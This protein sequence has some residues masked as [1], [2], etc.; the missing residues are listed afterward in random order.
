MTDYGRFMILLDNM[1]IKYRTKEFEKHYYID[2]DY[3][4][5]RQTY[6][7]AITIEFDSDGN[8]ITFEAWGE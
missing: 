8:F 7:N 5:I 6:G 4:Y 3:K 2:I 1:G